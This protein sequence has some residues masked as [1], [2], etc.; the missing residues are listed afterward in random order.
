MRIAKIWRQINDLNNGSNPA[1]TV[2]NRKKS[3]YDFC[4]MGRAIKV[5]VVLL[6]LICVLTLCIAPWV[7][8]PETTLKALQVILFLI[9]TF[10][11]FAFWLVGILSPKSRHSDKPA[12]PAD[13]PVPGLLPPCEAGCVQRC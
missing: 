2:A 11:F 8:P 5:V 3:I 6:C 13:F 4:R 12:P 10:A 7:D 1:S 9:S